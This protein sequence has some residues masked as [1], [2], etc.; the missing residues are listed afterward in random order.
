MAQSRGR[1]ARF[2]AI[3]EAILFAGHS[4]VYETWVFF[5]RVSGPRAIVTLRVGLAILSVSFV[6][7]T[8]LAY[9]Y[10]NFVVRFF[11]KV[12][13]VWMGILNFAF[14]AAGGCWIIYGAAELAGW[15]GER[16]AIAEALFGAALAASVYGAINARWIRVRRI[17]VQLAGLPESWRGRQAALVADLH[18]GH[19]N[20]FGFMRRL[21]AKLRRLRPDVVFIAGDMYDGTKVD[22]Q[23]MAEPW[24]ELAA[25]L[26]AYF[27][28]GNHEEFSDP[29]KYLAAL[30][31]AGVRVLRSEKVEVDGLQVAGLQYHDTTDARHYL[32]VLERIGLERARAS[33]LLAHVPHGLE[34]AADAGV[35]MQVSGHTHGGQMFPFTWFTRRIFGAYTYG[36][37]EFGE[38]AVYTTSG[39]GTWGPPL[40]VGTRA[41]IVMIRFD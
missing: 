15:R 24:K 2:V 32:S 25:P 19:V 23:R 9:R 29:A 4:F 11:Y 13:A 39:A 33:I 16:A 27:V 3:F 31:G 18:L 37:Q 10:S 22:T 7:A 35:S 40:R 21:V 28:T 30:S 5:V 26:G 38:M 20:G 14:L 8:L 41:E 34:V 1:I 17:S 12:A 36:L 6:T